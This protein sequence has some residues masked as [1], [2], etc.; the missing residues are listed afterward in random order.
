MFGSP[1]SHKEIE[2]FVGSIQKPLFQSHTNITSDS[3]LCVKSLIIL[4]FQENDS[5]PFEFGCSELFFIIESFF[6]THF[7][8]HYYQYVGRLETDEFFFAHSSTIF[9]FPKRGGAP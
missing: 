2:A 6:L 3:N 7:K 8:F 4:N 9:S 1:L 5:S